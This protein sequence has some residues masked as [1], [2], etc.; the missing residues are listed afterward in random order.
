LLWLLSELFEQL[1]EVGDL[2]VP[3]FALFL[4]EA[5][6]LF[7]GMP[8]S[9]QEKIEQVV[10]LIRSK[11][12][13]V[14]FITQSPLDLPAPIAAQLGLKIQHALRAFTPK[15]QKML[16][17]V[18]AGFC[19]N[20]DFSTRERLPALSVGEALVSSLDAKGA[21]T[22]V[23]PTLL[24]PPLSRIGPLTEAERL[25]IIAQSAFAGRF[26][27]RLNRESACESLQQRHQ[28]PVAE[29][30][31]PAAPAQEDS[32]RAPT[33]RPRAA[34]E[35]VGEAFLKSVGRA[36]GSQLGRQLVRGVLGALLKK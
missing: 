16:D 33:G 13:G 17:A 6:L 26:D 19:T 1:P 4:D 34:R 21:P 28:T 30:E 11:G 3:R 2:D 5:H 22:P 7:N 36:V 31:P 29:A 15:D 27:Q 20:P 24:A 23:L 25:T 9:L 18:A 10:R 12:V 8:K 32:A 14:F 35:S